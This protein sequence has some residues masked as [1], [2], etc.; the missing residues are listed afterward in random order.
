VFIIVS[1]CWWETLAAAGAGGGDSD[2]DSD[3][4]NFGGGGVP[5]IF[6]RVEGGVVE[7]G[8]SSSERLTSSE[9]LNTAHRVRRIEVSWQLFAALGAT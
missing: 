5:V 7:Y 9:R 8:M 3:D 1:W 2:S 4:G 6:D